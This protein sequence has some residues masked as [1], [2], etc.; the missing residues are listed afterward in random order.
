MIVTL[1]QGADLAAVRRELARRGLWV[2]PLVGGPSPQLAVRAD[3]TP[4]RREDL[5]AVPGV[6]GVAEPPSEHPRV[7]AAR[8]PVR[9]GEVAIGP[10]A[11]HVLVAG[12][13]AVESEEQID[14][15]AQ[16]VARAGARVLRGGA[17][18][19]RSSPY[20]FQG[21]GVAALG[22]LRDA[23]RRAGL[24]LVTEVT[25]PD[26]AEIV[27]T[28]ADALQIGSRNMQS[29]R[30][31]EA[32]AR[33]GRP[34]L[35]KRGM[36]ATVEEWLLA[37]EYGLLHGAAGVVLCE[38]GLRSFDAATRNL[39]D[40]GSVALVAHVHGLPVLVDPSHALGRRDLIA[41][42][43]RASLAAGAHGLVIEV[44]DDP[45][46]ALS[47]G[48]QALHP[49]ELATLWAPERESAS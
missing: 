33:T 1:E 45:G 5:L 39:L 2:T 24:A 23:A 7:D 43:A 47:D 29:F 44:H 25:S 30:L 46:A 37:A 28:H 11:R 42:L 34:L 32:V 21:H 40:L 38:R 16:A 22:W 20:S 10:G 17:F 31:L 18:K 49:D 15:L 27:A 35:L 9:F 6:I 41:P 3:S 19:P 4:A 36:S 14:R 26:D 12:P 13:C 8:A 48:P